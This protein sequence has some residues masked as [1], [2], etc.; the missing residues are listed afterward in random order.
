MIIVV[1][2]VLYKLQ[3]LYSI[4]TLIPV[5]SLSIIALQICYIDKLT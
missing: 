3:I 1:I 5:L 4:V 2:I